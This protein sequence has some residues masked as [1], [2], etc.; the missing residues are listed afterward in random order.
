M[1]FVLSWVKSGLLFGIL[2]SVVL[3]L[4]PNKSYMKH[5]GMIV[6]LLFILVMI[7]PVMELFHLEGST[8]ASY[9]RNFLM[10]ET[11]NNEIS[12]AD[13]ELYE[14]SVSMQLMAVLKEHAYPVK[15]VMVKAGEDG[16]IISV[17]VMFDS[18]VEEL[19]SLETYLKNLFGEEVRIRYENE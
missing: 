8:Y 17:S 13:L 3:M 14:E 11:E 9:V 10:M 7:H 4:S 6:G 19:E 1:E 18:S 16:N 5:I 12:G 15:N 2:S